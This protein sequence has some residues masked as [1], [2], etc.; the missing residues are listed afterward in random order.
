MN[1]KLP[2]PC[3]ACNGSGVRD[4]SA[5]SECRGKGYHL[6]V[7]GNQVSPMRLQRRQRQRPV[8]RQQR[9]VR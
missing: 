4:G 3:Q 5:C 1:E 9:S 2:A 8:Q 6:F 7:N